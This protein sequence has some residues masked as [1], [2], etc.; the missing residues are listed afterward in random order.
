MRR[1]VTL[2]DFTPEELFQIPA[3]AWNAL[4]LW[5][6]RNTLAEFRDLPPVR[7]RPSWAVAVTWEE[8]SG[9][10]ASVAPGVVGWQ[11]ARVHG[12]PLSQRPLLPIPSTAWAQGGEIPPA[13][14]ARF[15]VRTQEGATQILTDLGGGGYRATDS[16]VERAAVAT[17]GATHTIWRAEV[18]LSIPRLRQR[19]ETLDDG[20]IIIGLDD[21]PAGAVPEILAGAALPST[22]LPPVLEVLQ[23]L[24]ADPGVDVVRVATIWAISPAGADPETVPDV[25]FR[26]EVQQRLFYD[27]GYRVEVPD[28]PA[29]GL[30]YSIP[31]TGLGGTIAQQILAQMNRDASQLDALREAG[32]VRGYVWSV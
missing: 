23:G 32:R 27:L 7:P 15:P 18:W 24:V 13:I 11:E 22:E 16:P 4:L 2:P 10:V 29:E 25:T 6:R 21:A 3:A 8:G 31:F 20:R 30:V 5:L 14:A 9:L 17:R 12:V 26:H 19:V 1:P 28:L